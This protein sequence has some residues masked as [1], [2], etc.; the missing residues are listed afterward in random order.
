M[1]EV[2]RGSGHSD[3]K[4]ASAVD[5]TYFPAAP[6]YGQRRRD[7]DAVSVDSRHRVEILH[8]EPATCQKSTFQAH[9][10]CVETMEQVHWAHR[11][12]LSDKKVA[13]ATHNIV[14][15]KFCDAVRGVV[16]ADNDD[17]GETAAGSRLAELLELRGVVGV[18]VMVSRWY[19]GVQLG[20]ERFK[21]INRVAQLLLDSAGMSR[22]LDAKA[23]RKGR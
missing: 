9:L 15:Y 6:Q 3:A 5:F 1:A 20:P 11:Q 14:A 23:S 4:P 16:V 7:F 10:A 21:Q 2:E 12:L 22:H 18:F 8:G 17:D 19:G 13:V